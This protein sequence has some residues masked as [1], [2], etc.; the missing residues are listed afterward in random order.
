MPEKTN[1]G[2]PDFVTLVASPVGWTSTDTDP[3][4]VLPL[5]YTFTPGDA[6]THT[7]TD[8]G[9]GETTLITGGNQTITVTDGTI[10][11]DIPI[12]VDS[13][14][15]RPEPNRPHG[16]SR[17]VAQE[18]PSNSAAWLFLVGRSPL[19]SPSL[20]QDRIERPHR[21]DPTIPLVPAVQAWHL[22][23][24]GSVRS[25]PSPRA[26]HAVIDRLFGVPNDKPWATAGWLEQENGA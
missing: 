8:T 6:G 18:T 3:G 16:G 7:F 9:R 21:T 14:G 4:V 23:E 19:A 22:A 10:S 12:T 24:Q 15:S 11:I 26:A 5:D 1:F 2:A 13:S 17:A 25:K 20:S